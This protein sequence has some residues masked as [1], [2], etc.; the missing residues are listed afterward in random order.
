MT[1]HTHNTQIF[2]CTN[3]TLMKILTLKNTSL[4]S[5]WSICVVYVL[6]AQSCLSL[7]DPMSCSPPGSSVHGIFLARILEWVAFPSS[8]GSTPPRDQSFISCTVGGF[9]TCQVALM[10]RNLPANAR[11]ARS[12]GLIPDWGRSP[13]EEMATNSRILAWEI[14]WIE[15]SCR[16]QS[17]WLQR[18]DWANKYTYEHFAC[19]MWCNHFFSGQ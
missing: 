16:P 14:P 17:P 6:V 4:I 2:T 19:Q 18:L 1:E 12:V 3:K 5:S 10:V 8:R 11:D 15:E 7:W 9:L 13:A